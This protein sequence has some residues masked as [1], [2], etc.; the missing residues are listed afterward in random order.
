MNILSF[1][2]SGN[3]LIM[4]LLNYFYLIKDKNFIFCNFYRCCKTT[5]CKF[6]KMFQKYHDFKL[7]LE[8]KDNEKYLI[9]YRKDMVEQLEAYFRYTRKNIGI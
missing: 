4:L 1:P 6:N 3:S 2:R 5:P 8:I 9:L 7:N